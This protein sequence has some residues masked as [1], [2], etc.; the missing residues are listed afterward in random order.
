M[1]RA[2]PRLFVALDAGS[3][4][5]GAGLRS[6][7]GF[8]LESHARVPL[9]AGALAPSA[10]APNVLRPG[11][12]A[13]ALRELARSLRLGPAPVCLLLPDG[14]ARLALLDV[15]ADVTPQQYARFRI[16]PA[17]PYAP[18]EAVIE[19]L[20]L[21]PGRAVVAAV[22]RTVIEGYEAVAEQAGLAQDRLDL[23][24]LAAL[25]GLLREP[26][27]A[28]GLTVDV[29]LG[30]AAFCLAAHQDGAL[31]ALRN[32]RRDP[33]PDEPRRLAE[34]VQRTSVLAGDGAG[35]R[36]RVVGAGAGDLLASWPATAGTAEPGWRSET[37]GTGV[38]ASE[39]AW[40]GGAAP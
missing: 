13:D 35:P 6:G 20:P 27:D 28:G 10:F 14:I 40:L 8:R 31:R 3:V 29:I 34:E 37:T 12:V 11:E 24:P 17:L 7:G 19:V 21:G 22:R 2:R 26:G 5:G 38:D 15:P 16:V 9:H 33:G 30:D 39:L 4:S 1:R 32:R 25:S 36:V 18:E 23:T